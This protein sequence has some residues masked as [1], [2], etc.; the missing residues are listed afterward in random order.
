[1]A[2]DQSNEQ[3]DKRPSAARNALAALVLV[4][5]CGLEAYLGWNVLGKEFLFDVT[6]GLFGAVLFYWSKP[7]ARGL[8]GWTV[9]CYERFP[10]LKVL[11]GSQHA[12][13]ELNY[14]AMYVC[15]RVCGAFALIASVLFLILFLRLQL[16]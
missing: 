6:Y 3:S 10:K 4:S 12:G 8:N 13:T 2:Q 14:K 11:P 5:F 15:F 1:M 7:M 16:K 9:R